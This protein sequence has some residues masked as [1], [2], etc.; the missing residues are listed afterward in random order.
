MK[1]QMPRMKRSPHEQ[2]KTK[3]EELSWNGQEKKNYW[4]GVR[5][6]VGGGEVLNQFYSL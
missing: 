6:C 1:K 4:G 3:T 5:V 2:R